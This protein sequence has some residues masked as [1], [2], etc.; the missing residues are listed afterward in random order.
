MG[1]HSSSFSLKPLL[2]TSP[3]LLVPFFSG[4]PPLIHADNGLEDDQ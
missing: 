1:S 4:C 3:Q 2:P